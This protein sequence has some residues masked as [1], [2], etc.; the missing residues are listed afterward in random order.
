MLARSVSRWRY[1]T[2]VSHQQLKA[3]VNG[4]PDFQND[5]QYDGLDRLVGPKQSAQAC[6]R[7]LAISPGRLRADTALPSGKQLAVFEVN[8]VWSEAGRNYSGSAITNYEYDVGVLG[9]SDVLTLLGVPTFLLVPGFLM[10]VVF[11]ALWNNLGSRRQIPLNAKSAEFWCAVILFSILAAIAYPSLT[12]RDYLSGY[13]PEDV[14]WV[15]VG[16]V[17]AAGIAWTVIVLIAWLQSALLQSRTRKRTFAENDSP[18]E[19]LQKLGRNNRGVLLEQVAYT[20]AAGKPPIRAFEL[21]RAADGQQTW[22]A[23]GI[24]YQ[25]ANDP[26]GSI[27]QQVDDALVANDAA[28]IARLF[29]R[30]A[31]LKIAWQETDGLRHAICVPNAAITEVAGARRILNE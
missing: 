25:V 22:I 1:T 4:T 15:W 21:A 11:T 27:R 31:E 12:G 10:V 30:Q 5:Y 18:L 6:R 14:F 9:E 20:P 26:N 3:F 8:A 13:R 24:S 29:E 2:S 7:L 23:P 28:T 19:V 16:S 17:C